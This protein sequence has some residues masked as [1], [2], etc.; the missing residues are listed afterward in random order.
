MSKKIKVLPMELYY[1][2]GVGLGLLA[3]FMEIR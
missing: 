3:Y 2:I 1:F